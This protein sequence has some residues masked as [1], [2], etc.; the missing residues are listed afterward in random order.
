M[1]SG[2]KLLRYDDLVEDSVGAFHSQS[3][4]NPRSVDFFRAGQQLWGSSAAAQSDIRSHANKKRKNRDT[5]SAGRS[6]RGVWNPA[7]SAQAPHT[8][9]DGPDRSLELR[10]QQQQQQ[11][12]DSRHA[13][14]EAPPPPPA[15]LNAR[16]VVRDA[17]SRHLSAAAKRSQSAASTHPVSAGFRFTAHAQALQA[18]RVGEEEEHDEKEEE[19]EEHGPQ[20]MEQQSVVASVPT[21]AAPASES[22]RDVIVQAAPS[23]LSIPADEPSLPEWLLPWRD[24]EQRVEPGL[25]GWEPTPYRASESSHSDPDSGS[26]EADED[27]SAS[28]APQTSG[29]AKPQ[30]NSEEEEAEVA[31]SLKSVPD[32]SDAD[33]ATNYVTRAEVTLPTS[34]SGASLPGQ[35]K[36][37]AAEDLNVGK[38]PAAVVPAVQE[39]GLATHDDTRLEED[40]VEE[41]HQSMDAD[42]RRTEEDEIE[43]EAEA[44]EE[45][46]EDWGEGYEWYNDEWERQMLGENA[47]P[48]VASA[49]M[50]MLAAGIGQE[51]D[52]EAE[53]EDQAAHTTELDSDGRVIRSL[54]HDELWADE[55][56]TSAF[57]AAVDQFKAMHSLGQNG[58]VIS[59][60]DSPPPAANLTSS[61]LWYDAPPPESRAAKSARKAGNASAKARKEESKA[62]RRH[63]QE[64]KVAAR[65]EAKR[66]QA[67]QDA[68]YA[69]AMEEMQAHRQIVAPL[70]PADNQ[71]PAADSVSDS[72][73]AT[74]SSNA[75]TLNSGPKRKIKG[76]I[77][78]SAPL[79]GR[80]AWLAACA[81]V[82]S[83]PN[84]V[85]GVECGGP[86]TSSTATATAQGGEQNLSAR[87]DASAS[88]HA[89]P[90]S[91]AQGYDPELLQ[92]LAHAWYYAG[93]YQG[94]AMAKHQS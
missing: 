57:S 63:A 4:R 84:C 6:T 36:S 17:T 24:P 20:Q 8:A 40:E 90:T 5:H 64:T 34:I 73:M 10:Q 32:R 44:M 87:A 55:A 7:A 51:S 42:I 56:M 94:I 81:T 19:G 77:P 67:E 43:E 27:Q 83:T 13:H 85:A 66:L 68:R 91:T 25:D 74:P 23:I 15:Q 78:P 54:T 92:S 22:P 80:P 89:A 18:S 59:A 86:K 33:P 21:L 79:S 71:P 37:S 11:Q 47:K 29:I 58:L 48:G 3:A 46:T 41:S 16:S 30:T 62:A 60:S 12:Q 72:K 76:T 35:S 65:K 9:T 75:E 28:R 61:A 14:P 38:S 2:R 69:Q 1:S 31:E 49:V 26:E 39:A 82:S 88:G 45:E 53:D 93:Y 52:E 50:A 70:Q